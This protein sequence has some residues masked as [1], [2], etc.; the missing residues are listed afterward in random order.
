MKSLAQAMLN[1]SS[2]LPLSDDAIK[3]RL[4]RAYDMV[5][6]QGSGYEFTRA[7]A[8]EGGHIYSVHRASTSLLEDNSATYIVNE[9]GCSCPD[10]SKTRAGLCKHRL[11]TMILEEMVH[12]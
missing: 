4:D 5:L 7:V 1:V 11:A 12:E 6:K 8:T 2:Q 3:R 10:A 9:D